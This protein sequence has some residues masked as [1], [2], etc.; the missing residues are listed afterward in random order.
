MEEKPGLDPREREAIVKEYTSTVSAANAKFSLELDQ[1]NLPQLSGAVSRPAMEQYQGVAAPRML[2]QPPRQVSAAGTK[3]GE[4]IIDFLLTQ[5]TS[6]DV[7][8]SIDALKHLEKNMQTNLEQ[9]K[10][11]INPLINAINLQVRLAFT[12]TGMAT[13]ETN[14]LVRL[15]RHL[16]NALMNIASNPELASLVTRET[17]HQLLAELLTRLV[18]QGVHSETESGVQLVR[19]LNVLMLRILENCNSNISFA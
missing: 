3:Q 12:S 9:V 18:D 17:M 2:A 6:G 4:Y 8:Q 19:A 14:T 13:T 11:Q 7:L 5:I 10:Q 16:V 1:L 15:C